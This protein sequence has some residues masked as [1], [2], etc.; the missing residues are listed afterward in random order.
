MKIA[1]HGQGPETMGHLYEGRTRSSQ[2][3][4]TG[5][6]VSGRVIVGLKWNWPQPEGDAFGLGHA[7]ESPVATLSPTTPVGRAPAAFPPV[8]AYF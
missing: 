5:T 8:G 6:A 4:P 2:V 1:R 3:Q 7:G